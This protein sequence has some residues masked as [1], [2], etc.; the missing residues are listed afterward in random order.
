MKYNRSLSLIITTFLLSLSLIVGWNDSASGSSKNAQSLQEIRFSS[1]VV[2]ANFAN[3]SI[4]IGEAPI[5]GSTTQEGEETVITT[6]GKTIWGQ[7]D[8][9][10]Y[11]Y[12]IFAGNGSMVTRV[13][14]ISNSDGWAKAGIMIRETLD[15]DSPYA[16]VF[17]T[18][19][20]G[21]SFQYR[22]TKGGNSSRKD[23]FS[24]SAPYWLK[25]ERNGNSF[26][27][28]KS[29]DGT[30][31]EEFGQVAI[32]LQESVYIGLAVS[33][34]NT[35][36][37]NTSRFDNISIIIDTGTGATIFPDSIDIGNVPIPG[38]ASQINEEVTITSSGQ[39]IWGES[40]SFHYAYK[41]LQGNGSI[42]T[43]V[44]DVSNS[45]AWAKAGIMIRETLDANSPHAMAFVTSGKGISFQ[46]RV[47]K[48]GNSDRK[49]LFSGSA[50]YW[51]K[52]E[53]TDNVFSAYRSINGTEWEALGE[54]TIPMQYSVYIGLAVSIG[55]SEQLSSSRFDNIILTKEY[56]N[57]L[58]QLNGVDIGDIALAGS[59]T[60]ND[61]NV[62]VA[63]TGNIWHNS[64]SFHYA[65]QGLH[66]NGSMTVRIA[67][68]TDT[69]H[70]A[71][72]G[73]MVRETLDADSPHAMAYL[74]S[75]RGISLQYRLTKA[76]ST[77]RYDLLPGS[78]PYWLKLERKDDV[79]SAYKSE[80]GAVW[81]A[82]GQITIPMPRSVYIGL[83][84]SS[85]D[86]VQL[87]T[88]HFENITFIEETLPVIARVK[89]KDIG[90]V[91]I[92]GSAIASHNGVTVSG[93]G[94]D[95]CCGSD[96][97]HF[98][99]WTI[100]GDGTM[101]TR[102]SD[103]T[104]TDPWAKAGIMIRE[105]L[106]ADSPHAMALVTPEQGTSLAYR[107]TK[108]DQGASANFT[109]GSAPYW[110]KLERSGE[111]IK[112][113]KSLD[114]NTWEDIGQIT[115]PMDR[116][117]YI[118]LAVTANNNAAL[119]RSHFKY[120]RFSEDT[121]L[122]YDTTANIPGSPPI[123]F[124]PQR[125]GYRN[126]SGYKVRVDIDDT[127]SGDDFYIAPEFN[128]KS[129]T[130]TLEDN[131]YLT[132]SAIT[133]SFKM[134]PDE[135]APDSVLMQSDDFFE[136]KTTAGNIEST[137]YDNGSP[138][139]SITT[140]QSSLKIH[141]ANHVA[142]VLGAN[143]HKVYLNGTLTETQLTQAITESQKRVVTI[144]PYQGKIWDIKIHNWEV[145]REQLAEDYIYGIDDLNKAAISPDPEYPNGLC[146]V[147]RCFWW[148]LDED[149]QPDE[150]PLPYETYLY[151]L[152]AH[153]NL[154]IKNYY[155]KASMIPKGKEVEFLGTAPNKNPILG[156]GIR[157]TFV[158]PFS[159][160]RP[161]DP[162][163]SYYWLHENFHSLQGFIS[164]MPKWFMEAT[165]EWAPE[166]VFPGSST[167]SDLLG[168]Y[169]YAPHMPLWINQNS[170]VNDLAGWQYKGGHMYGAKILIWYLANYYS[171]ASF[172]G[173]I[174][175][176]PY[177]GHRPQESMFELMGSDPLTGGSMM[178]KEFAN[179]A[180]RTIT[181]DYAMG[182][183][184]AKEERDSLG[185]IKRKTGL[186][187]EEII[188]TFPMEYLAEGTGDVWTSVPADHMP[189]S[190]AY[191]AYK[192][193]NTDAGMYTI[194]FEGDIGNIP[195]SLFE[196]RVVVHDSATDERTYYSRNNI[197]NG[198]QIVIPEIPTNQGDTLYLVVATTPHI[199]IGE[200]ERYNYKFKIYK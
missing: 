61:N 151:Y 173:E 24:G 90:S 49:D 129:L 153:E 50:P 125:F 18:P 45:A 57:D 179:F 42:V 185:R 157:K 37:L 147:Y 154:S 142:A 180:A 118:G 181:W 22:L 17:V 152:Y 99:Y 146:G 35:E 126:I 172:I 29:I 114:G 23:L 111:V 76:G 75:Q 112:A 79:L 121:E 20:K 56:I 86:G 54:V 195:E 14:D 123:A 149:L 30:E 78:A 10:R 156:Y 98:A 87:N 69:H 159:F 167:D 51:I 13:S 194:E 135:G 196:V 131:T 43:R 162:D 199:F 12:Q 136:I 83:A 148:P 101:I 103:M 106:D 11:A 36:Q 104:D 144:G 183:A 46:Y 31:W 63:S 186:T 96:S 9:F 158:R 94:D 124:L 117:V 137:F 74:T 105:T 107:L 4:D 82:L 77:N 130:L 34:S 3:N 198:E 67:S 68:I 71:K 127:S 122:V 44:T 25:L 1:A 15:A 134:T 174:Y 41:A 139:S 59:T 116:F 85:N 7:N 66:G 58:E 16:M 40:D 141:R 200:T 73:I 81:Q 163:N 175:N 110:L 161:L 138:A 128:K 184:F 72:A 91:G 169:T 120:I 39:T 6:S 55:N 32:P 53:R 170:D 38:S 109:P 155:F 150:A 48:G 176:H 97:F 160:D 93:S 19:D 102:V 62:T 192:C 197:S 52:L 143:S 89:S 164:D 168:F 8:S 190:W 193:E 33:C 5:A 70:F 132:T 188:N 115:L 26:V 171:D 28:Y 65:Y 108:G 27:A 95:I 47:T 145:P 60:Q 84:V 80:D 191:N 119:N 178:G 177:A 92:T 21:I 182:E 166:I 88:T 133:I 187:E 140:N 100:E 113:F 64:D 189:G 2:H 165:A